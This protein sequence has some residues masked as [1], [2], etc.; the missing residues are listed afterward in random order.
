MPENFIG[1]IA[2]WSIDLVDMLKKS[3]MEEKK[4]VVG[5]GEA[6]R[7][8]YLSGITILLKFWRKKSGMEQKM[9][10]KGGCGGRRC[11]A[12][13]GVKQSIFKFLICLNF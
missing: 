8:H 10:E 12:G 2:W 4:E 7:M 9:S 5:V 1:R 11:V 3:G 6:W 13:P